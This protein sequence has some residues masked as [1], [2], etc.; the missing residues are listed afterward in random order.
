MEPRERP[1]WDP[2]YASQ[3]LGLQGGLE[4][5]VQ[6]GRGESLSLSGGR[7]KGTNHLR[8]LRGRGLFRVGG[9]RIV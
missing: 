5:L 2:A 7:G 6:V 3:L 9:R 8:E 1:L 4:R